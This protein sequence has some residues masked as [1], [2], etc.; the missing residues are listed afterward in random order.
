[1]LGAGPEPPPSPPSRRLGNCAA[2]ALP[3]VGG[4]GRRRP[5]RRHPTAPV[6]WRGWAVQRLVRPAADSGVLSGQHPS[7][8]LMEVGLRS[9]VLVCEGEA[10]TETLR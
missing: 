2:R 5:R 4:A 7:P 1:M 3:S 10:G 6:S 8:D 9:G